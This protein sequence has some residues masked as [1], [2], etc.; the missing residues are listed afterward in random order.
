MIAPLSRK[1]VAPTFM[2][3]LRDDKRGSTLA[4]L[5][6]ALIPLSL[7]V[8]SGIDTA[9]L[10][11]V[12]VRLQQACDAGVL[13]GRKA[14]VS[15][16]STTLDSNADAQARTFFGNNFKAGW[17]KTNTVSFT[18]SKTSDQ[19]VSG[20]A[21]AVVPMTITGFFAPPVT[22]NVACEARYDVADT[23]IMFVLDTTGSMACTAAGSCSGTVDTYTRPDGTTG[24][25]AHE[26]SGSK[27]SGLRTAVLNFYDT[28][29]ANADPTTH[30]R[31]GFV[32]YTSTVNAGYALPQSAIVDSWTYQSRS[33]VGD[34][35]NG[36]S[37]NNTQTGVGQTNC[38]NMAGR[39]PASGFN[40]DGTAT[41]VTTSWSSGSGGTCVITTQPLKPTWRY[42]PVTYNT[43]QYKTGATVD[44]P[45]KVDGTTSK[46]QGCVEERDTTATATFD[47]NNLPPD[48]DPDLAASSDST[49]WRPMW[50]EVEYYRGNNTT[51][52]YSGNVSKP[53]TPPAPFVYGD[54]TGS[55]AT[56]S[57][58]SAG[59]PANLSSGYVSCGKPVSRLAV[60]ARSDVSNYVNAS[61]FVP[62][63]GTYHDTGMI[64]GT[65]MI[66]PNGV[67]ASDT[68]AWPGRNEPNRYIVFMTDGDMAPNYNI[69]GMYGMEYYD[70]RVTGSSGLGND[71]DY[72]NARFLAECAA[73]KARNIKVFVIGFGQ[74]LTTQLTQCASPG[75]AYYASD[76][77]SLN[78]AFQDIAKQVA[79]LRIS[80]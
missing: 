2:G 47:V 24:Y 77:A 22:I 52:D 15:S 66:A 48:L 60:M 20:V 37:S 64:W 70:K 38:N 53:S 4:M 39:S 26:V 17:M 1:P 27:I 50:P 49:K 44:D 7:M 19:Q 34:A 58:T 8:G 6:I 32:T 45:S 57:L 71:T 21:S 31:Y 14:L 29:A 65:R 28:V 61:D 67:F 73:A 5:A 9:R 74:T 10:Y 35:N 36:S 79:L 68:A 11:V 72:H 41:R 54:Y 55:G 13:A 18:P 46:W 51:Y 30:I 56:Q 69:Y 62:Q 16:S 59:A 40:T 33:I 23:D 42:Q 76:N 80:Q 63:G 75:K 3:R 12:K 78:Q 25:H 43:S